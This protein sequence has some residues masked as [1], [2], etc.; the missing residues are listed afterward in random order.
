LAFEQ[1]RLNP[2]SVVKM[3]LLDWLL[4]IIRTYRDIERDLLSQLDMALLVDVMTL[5]PFD[6]TDFEL[7]PAVYLNR[8]PLFDQDPAKATP[9]GVFADDI[10]T[11]STINPGEILLLQT[12][13][14]RSFRRHMIA[15]RFSLSSLATLDHKT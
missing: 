2:P 1:L 4:S 12:H 7:F 6:L 5:T 9:R 11:I 13:Y 14:A 3:V 8:D 10:S 15:R